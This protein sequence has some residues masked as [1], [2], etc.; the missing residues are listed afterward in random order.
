MVEFAS[1][2][3]ESDQAQVHCLSTFC[4]H[5]SKVE[6]RSGPGSNM[7]QSCIISHEYEFTV[8]REDYGRFDGSKLLI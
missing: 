4:F 8:D 2:G 1:P 5:G 6:K 3:F 7:T